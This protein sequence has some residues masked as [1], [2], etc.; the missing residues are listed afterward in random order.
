MSVPGAVTDEERIESGEVGI[1]VDGGG[2]IPGFSARLSGT[3]AVAGL[4]VVHEA[5]GLVDHIRDVACRFAQLG[6]AVI[7]PDL[8][9]RTGAP[10]RSDMASVLAAMQSLSDSGAVKDIAAS[11]S[12]AGAG[13]GQGKR[14]GA[15]G[16]SSGGRQVLLSACADIGLNAAVDC[17]GGWIRR[18]GLD[19]EA[20]PERPVP[21]VAL[22]ARLRCRLFAAFGAEDTNPSPDDAEALRSA[23]GRAAARAL[24]RVYE[25][26]G[27][28]FFADYRP[29][30]REG[31]AR[32]LWS[33]VTAFLSENLPDPQAS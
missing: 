27:H 9:S 26:A 32:R 1:P 11:V 30:Y 24:V 16:F 13:A 6:C 7:A 14:V 18:A 33:D 15:I 23:A 4:G 12:L 25:G 3:E 8:Y 22:A 29:T 5:F 19:A 20:T 10:D 21:P 31:P 28:A 2:T 17:W